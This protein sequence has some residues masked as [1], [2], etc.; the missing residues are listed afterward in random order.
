MKKFLLVSLFALS[1]A[2]CNN[3]EKN[4]TEN[5]ADTANSTPSE[6]DVAKDLQQM[7]DSDAH[8]VDTLLHL[9]PVP[10]R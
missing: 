6:A 8:R 3:S 1:L 7:A 2:A 5:K 10:K 9:L 4:K